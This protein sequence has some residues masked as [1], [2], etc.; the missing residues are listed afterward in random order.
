MKQT[1]EKSSASTQIIPAPIKRVE[2]RRGCY[3][4][5]T[6]RPRLH[7][8]GSPTRVDANAIA[9]HTV[10]CTNLPQRTVF[11]VQPPRHPIGSLRSSRSEI[12]QPNTVTKFSNGNY[13]VYTRR[14]VRETSHGGNDRERKR[15]KG[16]EANGQLV[17]QWRD[18]WFCITR[19]IGYTR[20]G[21]GWGPAHPSTRR[22]TQQVC[23]L[24]PC[25]YI[26][27]SLSCVCVHR[28]TLAPC[29]H[30]SLSLFFSLDP[31][32]DACS[33]S[34]VCTPPQTKCK[35]C[36]PRESRVTSAREKNRGN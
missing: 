32:R 9:S 13:S 33:L 6:Y 28:C 17:S 20:H 3:F 25:G 18:D 8:L 1:S 11:V 4:C 16:L 22:Y 2:R 12:L 31:T 10:S 5:K 30:L 21:G 35:R 7:A 14:N 36:T 27:R 29:M 23:L 24:P 34:R 26:R 15:E 19:L